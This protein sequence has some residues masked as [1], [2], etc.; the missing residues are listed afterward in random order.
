MDGLGHIDQQNFLV[1]RRSAL[2]NN[3]PDLMHVSARNDDQIGSFTLTFGHGNTYGQASYFLEAA[4]IFVDLRRQFLTVQKGKGP[5]SGAGK[6]TSAMRFGWDIGWATV[7]N[8][9]NR[10]T[11]SHEREPGI[12]G[13]I[14]NFYRA[15]DGEE[16]LAVSDGTAAGVIALLDQVWAGIESDNSPSQ[17]HASSLS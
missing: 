3:S 6:I 1:G 7:G 16:D 10:V 12:T 4:T 9:G 2:P 14:K 5:Q 15:I 11:G 13:L 8:I 17:A